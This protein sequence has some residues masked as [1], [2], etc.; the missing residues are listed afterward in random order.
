MNTKITSPDRPVR[1]GRIEFLDFAKG[2]AMLS[3][4]LY[5]YFRGFFPGIGDKIVMAGGAGVHLFLI[6]S[7]FGLALSGRQLSVSAFYRKRFSRVLVPYFLAITLIF[8]INLFLPLYPDAGLY[9]YLGNILFFKMFDESIINSFGGHFWFLSTIIQFYLA[10][11]LLDRQLRR[12]QYGRFVGISLFI[13]MSFFL[14]LY[15]ARWV[16]T[17]ARSSA[18]LTGF[19]T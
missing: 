18:S 13:S 3:I 15:R 7:G 6:L 5:H 16:F 17:L 9:A 19:T 11:P 8:L 12:K 2:C 14:V 1:S 4:V 10:Y